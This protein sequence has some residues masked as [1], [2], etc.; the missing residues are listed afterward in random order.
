M[1]GMEEMTRAEGAAII[2]EIMEAWDKY[3]AL[4]LEKFGNDNDFGKWFTKQT[5]GGNH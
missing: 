2:K 5:G 4:W 3:R 1:K